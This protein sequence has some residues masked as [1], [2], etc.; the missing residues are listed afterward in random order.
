MADKTWRTYEEVAQYLLNQF[1]VHLGLERVEGK[2][3]ILGQLSGRRIEIDVRGVKDGNSGFVML[4]CK[5]Y[6]GRVEAKNWKR[7]LPHHR[8]WRG[9]RDRRCCRQRA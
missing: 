8:R 7:S 1:A 6:K 2:Q 3:K 9:R 5:R 4:E